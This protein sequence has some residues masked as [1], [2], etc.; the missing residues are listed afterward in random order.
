[1][2]AFP[3]PTYKS[4]VAVV[5][6]VAAVLPA[7]AALPT[8]D[9]FSSCCYSFSCCLQFLRC[10]CPCCCRSCSCC[11]ISCWG[12]GVTSFCRFL[13]TPFQSPW[14]SG[15]L[16]DLSFSIASVVPIVVGRGCGA[17]FLPRHAL[18]RCPAVLH[19]QQ[20]GRRSSTTTRILLS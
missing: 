2:E 10:P 5:V 12:I 13:M 6:V 15:A 16:T 7:A 1:M 20:W 4:P 18:N 8:A 11:G 14:P 19:D 3:P 9:V 17:V